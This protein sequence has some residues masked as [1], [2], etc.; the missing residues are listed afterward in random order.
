MWQG[1]MGGLPEGDTETQKRNARKRDAWQALPEETRAQLEAQ[2]RTP[3]RAK[4]EARA[5]RA[6]VCVEL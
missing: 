1:A 2:G 6:E 4:R 3:A 5:K